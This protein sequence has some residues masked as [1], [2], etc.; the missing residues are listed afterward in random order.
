MRGWWSLYTTWQEE[1][2]E[3]TQ[4]S[5]IDKEHIAQ[6]VKE[7]YTEGELIREKEN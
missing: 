5:E 6:C 7:G 2:D 3:H 1:P 4:L